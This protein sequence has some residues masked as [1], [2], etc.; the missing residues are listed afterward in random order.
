[1]WRAKGQRGSIL[2]ACTQHTSW[3]DDSLD[4]WT[5]N[6]AQG[7]LSPPVQ[8]G[9]HHGW[10]LHGDGAAVIVDMLMLCGSRWW[11]GE[12]VWDL[13]QGRQHNYLGCGIYGIV[14][15]S[16]SVVIIIVCDGSRSAGGRWMVDDG[17]GLSIPSTIIL[18]SWDFMR[19]FSDASM[20]TCT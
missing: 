6:V 16:S 15:L 8:D 4:G 14:L 10:L 20:C 1:M 17:N 9:G 7:W 13:W 12:F 19:H 2:T 18:F 3:C 5:M 11:D